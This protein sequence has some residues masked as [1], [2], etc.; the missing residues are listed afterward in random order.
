MKKI[1]MPFLLAIAALPFIA[2]AQSSDFQ[3]GSVLTVSNE[4][5]E[6]SIRDLTKNKGSILFTSASGEKKT[7]T[8]GDILGFTLNGADYISYASDFYK[9]ISNGSKAALYQR[10]TDNSGKMLYNGAEAVSVTTAEGKSGD[11]YIQVKA[12]G[13]FALV[14]AKNFD[15]VV[16]VLFA[17]CAAVVADVKAKQLDYTQLAKAVE[18]YN[19]SN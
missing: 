18:K 17:G 6:G 1:I 15:K 7:Y 13:K 4:K 14:T 9:V 3:K 10:A 11:L 8:P 19:T 16:P 5:T 12:D 2:S